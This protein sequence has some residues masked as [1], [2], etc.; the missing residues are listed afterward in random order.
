VLRATTQ[1]AADLLGVGDDTGTLAPGKRA[2]VV[3]VAGDPLDL[4]SLRD[5]I[6]AV[7][8][9]GRLVRGTVGA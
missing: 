5:N 1:S 2:D 3:A 6:R 7:Y 8:K 4:A 9:D